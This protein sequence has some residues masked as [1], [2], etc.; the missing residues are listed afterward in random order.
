MSPDLQTTKHQKPSE[1]NTSTE[2]LWF[3]ADGKTKWWKKSDEHQCEG[4]EV[5]RA[6]GDDSVEDHRRRRTLEKDVFPSLTSGKSEKTTQRGRK[7]TCN[8][9]NPSEKIIIRTRKG[10][11]YSTSCFCSSAHI[12]TEV[13]FPLKKELQLLRWVTNNRPFYPRGWWKKRL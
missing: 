9:I 12:E 10:N 4:V 1:R 8:Y 6:E 3:T 11:S 13:L 7:A 2:K 5:M